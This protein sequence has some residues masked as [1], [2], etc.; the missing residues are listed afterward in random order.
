MVAEYTT[1]Q[2][3]Q[4]QKLY[5]ADCA[6]CHGAKLEGGGGP[7]LTGAAWLQLYGGARLLMGMFKSDGPPGEARVER[8]KAS[9]MAVEPV[10]TW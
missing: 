10:K 7:A 8:C 5:A 4:G 9:W 1:A 6:S 2:A 3:A